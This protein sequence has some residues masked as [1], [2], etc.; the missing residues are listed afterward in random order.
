V[1][2]LGKNLH[3]KFISFIFAS[4]KTNKMKEVKE[5]FTTLNEFRK[6]DPKEFYGSIAFMVF[7]FGFF[8]VS[9]WFGAII[10]GRV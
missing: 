10:E 9:M 6:E 5:M 1:I 7:M 3:I 2:S 4:T 8:Y